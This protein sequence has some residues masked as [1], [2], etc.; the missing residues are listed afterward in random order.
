MHI[1]HENVRYA[2]GSVWTEFYVGNF[3]DK[4]GYNS[5]LDA[6]PEDPKELHLMFGNELRESN[7]DSN[8]DRHLS[9]ILHAVSE[10]VSGEV[11]PGPI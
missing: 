6:S 11:Y 10:K 5:Y 2:I 3:G 1:T 8:L 9:V 4:T 7:Q